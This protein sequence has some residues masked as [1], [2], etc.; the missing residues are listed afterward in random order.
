MDEKVTELIA[1]GASVVANCQPC[2][3]FHVQKAQAMGIS[4]KELIIA[5]KVAMQVKAGAAEKSEAH[6]SELLGNLKNQPV[7]SVCDCGS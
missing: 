6:V 7:A 3:E 2:V 5:A 4:E 1:V